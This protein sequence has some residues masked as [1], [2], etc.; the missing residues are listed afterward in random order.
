MAKDNKTTAIHFSTGLAYPALMDILH[1]ILVVYIFIIKINKCD[2]PMLFKLM[3]DW[4]E[5]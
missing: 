4:Y 2:A 5:D 1:I 3:M